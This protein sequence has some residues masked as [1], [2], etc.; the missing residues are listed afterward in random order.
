MPQA[1]HQEGDH[2]IHKGPQFSLPAASQRKIHIGLQKTAQGHVPPFPEILH[3]YR[4]V[5]RVEV[6]R[7][8]DPEQPSRADGHVGIAAE[9]KVQLQGIACRRKKGRGSVQGGEVLIAVI[10][11]KGKRIR[12]KHFFPE[13]DGK[14]H[15]ALCKPFGR[16]APSSVIL[17]L[18][19]RG[20]VQD[21]GAGDQRG[22]K[23]HEAEVIQ[24]PAMGRVP[25]AAVDEEGKLLEGEKADPKRQQKLLC[26]QL[27]PEKD[28]D[29]LHKKIIVLEN[30]QRPD[31]ARTS[32]DEK[33]PRR[34]QRILFRQQEAHPVIEQAASQHDPEKA[35]IVP[36]IKPQGHPDEISLCQFEP[37]QPVEQ[38]PA[39]QR[40]RQKYKNKEIGMK[41]H[42]KL[43]S[44]IWIR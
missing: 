6:F 37:L 3:G 20:G 38:I 22:E 43:R 7:D 16:K 21:D 1:A 39:G 31:V 9:V 15:H 33:D 32:G 29:I 5:W 41:L 14:P 44:V 27:C 2:G 19:N 35:H 40:Q 30:A 25:P 26:R 18:G 8:L 17:K 11:G 28:V 23:G 12:K 34:P 10:H 4:P 42:L 24:K 13:A 36:G